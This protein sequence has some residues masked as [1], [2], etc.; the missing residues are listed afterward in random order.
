MY[1]ITCVMSFFIIKKMKIDRGCSTRMAASK[2]VIA[3]AD[4]LL[5]CLRI[6]IASV[7]W[8]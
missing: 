7:M 5:N 3:V 2:K 8:F 4:L 1:P 6:Y